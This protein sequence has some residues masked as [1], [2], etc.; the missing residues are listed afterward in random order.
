MD[1]IYSQVLTYVDNRGR[2]LE[3]EVPQGVASPLPF[4]GKPATKYFGQGTT[5]IK[6]QAS[7][8]VIARIS[9]RF[10]IL[11]ESIDQAFRLYDAAAHKEGEVQYLRFREQQQGPS[12]IV[13]PGR[14]N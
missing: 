2:R 3:V 4:P 5:E 6:D 8:R 14:M 7:G 13:P 11:A 12:I 1:P 10:E 9:F